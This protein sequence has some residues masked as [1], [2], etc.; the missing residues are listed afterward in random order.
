MN[1]IIDRGNTTIKL[2][3]FDAGRMEAFASFDR[4][5]EREVTEFL[6][7]YPLDA[8]I[9]SSVACQDDEPVSFFRHRIP[10]FHRFSS[11]SR[12]PV[13]IGYRTPETLG[14]DRIA[15]VV[16]AA[17]EKPGV[18]VLVV[19][20]GTAVTYDVL[21]GDGL[22]VGGN[23][24]PGLQMRL[25]A[26]HSFTARLPR[27]SAE[28]EVPL[29]G[30]D[31][32]T[33]IR[34]GVVQGICHEID[35]YVREL[36]GKYPGLLVFLTGGDAFLFAERLKTPIFVDKNIVIKGLNRILYCNCNVKK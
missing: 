10:R 7:D 11:E 4:W 9:Y 28:G 8:C 27:V 26:L 16:G 20:A 23:I 31:T 1:L 22:F 2:A 35:G 24:A 19:D 34:A 17:G 25:Q 36:S 30:Y 18:P 29:L 6:A 14:L 13:Q 33:A 12:L 5:E 32:E 3:V 21:T 15:G